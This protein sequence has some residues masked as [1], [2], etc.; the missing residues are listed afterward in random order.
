MR[1]YFFALLTLVGIAGCRKDAGELPYQKLYPPANIT[2][3]DVQ[4][5]ENGTI[6]I[7][8]GD[9]ENGVI[10][11]SIDKG[12]SW[13]VS[14]SFFG[15]PINTLF[16]LN[17]NVGFAADNDI[18][19]FKTY[20]GGYT[21]EQFYDTQWPLTVNRNLRNIWFS[22]DSTGFV[23]GGKN[24]GNGVIYSTINQGADWTF[25][26]YDHELRG[27]CFTDDHHGV[28]CGYGTIMVTADAGKTFTF[29]ESPTD[30][31]T[32]IDKDE[33]GTMWMCGF[34]GKI[35]SSIDHGNNWNKH[36]EGTAWNIA[37]NQLNCIDLS[38]GGKIACAGPN[39]FITWS[40]DKGSTWSNKTSFEGHDIL[41][42][43]WL[44]ENELIAVGKSGGVY[45]VVL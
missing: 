21:W 19:I 15:D 30:Y 6:L 34:N 28:I 25:S 24:Y 2:Y 31:F 1:N 32:G 17:E 41:S 29:L 3:R 37:G 8:G 27:I 12:N 35:Y 38:P 36:R 22:D 20:N 13:I 9:Q 14:S 16:F 44:S 43:K 33:M 45:K 23:C 39:G 10:F 11:R 4:V 42:I 18:L 7:C 5:L 26:E 40:A